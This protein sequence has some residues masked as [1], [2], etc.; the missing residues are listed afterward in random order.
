MSKLTFE[1]DL[2]TILDLSESISAAFVHITRRRDLKEDAKGDAILALINLEFNANNGGWRSY[3]KTR[4]LGLLI[5]DYQNKTGQRLKRKPR[6]TEYL[7][8]ASNS[9]D[10]KNDD[11]YSDDVDSCKTAINNALRH[12]PKKSRDV[13]S[14]WIA[15]KKQTEIAKELGLTRGRVSQ[16]VSSFKTSARIYHDT[17]T[18]VAV[19]DPRT[20]SDDK[21]RERYPLF[22]AN[23]E[24]QTGCNDIGDK[25][26]TVRRRHETH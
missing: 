6:F 1:N 21:T 9:D 16:I 20:F 23:N 3:L 25:L 7:E 5:R 12:F 18:A 17:G 8:T 13:L 24:K 22:F 2:Q 4:A 11:C 26:K 19:V 10:T 14:A 15:G